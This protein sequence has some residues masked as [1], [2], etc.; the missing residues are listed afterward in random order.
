MTEHPY[1][2]MRWLKCDLHMHTPGDRRHWK[3]QKIVA[4]Q[5][6]AAAK[7]FARACYEA[8]LDVVGVTDHNLLGKAFLPH[9]QSAFE[10][11][12]NEFNH[13]ITMFPGVEFEA[14][15]GKGMHVVCLFDP[16]TDLEEIDH[17][18]TECGVPRPRVD[19]GTLAKSTKRLPRILDVVQKGN[20]E[21][22]WRGILIIPHV[23]D[24]SLFDNARISEWLQQEEFR[25]P[26]VLAAEIPKPVT[27][28]NY[29]FQKLFR[30]DDDCLPEWRRRRP[31]APLMSSD[32]KTLIETES[33]GRP[34]PN[35]IGYRYS[36][37]KMSEPSIEALRQAF[38]DH[39]S[40]IILPDD[41]SS[42]T[43]PENR[44][45]QTTIRSLSIKNVAFLTDQE[46]HF[47]PNMNCVIGGRG[48]GK[49]TLLE[50]LRIMLGKEET[51]DRDD[52]T[53]E[54]IER[55]RDTLKTVGAEL[56]VH[57]R[58]SD[59]AEDHIVWKNGTP[60]VD[61]RDLTDPDTF[62]RN[63]PVRFY[64]Q[65]QLNRL[66]EA[67]SDDGSVRQA[68][69]L[70]ALVDGFAESD[71]AL[72]AE[73]ERKLTIDIE[74]AFAHLRKVDTLTGDLKRLRQE[75]EELDRQCKARSEIQAEARRHQFL[76]SEQRYLDG[77]AGPTGKQFSDVVDLAEAVA[78]S[79]APFTVADSPHETWLQQF[80]LKVKA[81][82]DKLATDIRKAVE[83]FEENIES[84]KTRDP[85]WDS[86]RTELE[87][88]DEKF[89][90][91]CEAKG[92]SPDDI[93]H[94]KDISDARAAK[95]EEM[96]ATEAEIDQ[97]KERAGDPEALM[98]RLHNVWRDQY[99]K[100]EEAAKRANE[101]A[102][103]SDRQQRFIE[104]TAE[105]QQDV[106]SFQ[107]IW[108]GFA[109]QDGRTRLGR[110]W[111]SIGEKLYQ[112][113]IKQ[114]QAAS[115]WQLLNERLDD[116]SRS[117]GIDFGEVS[118]ELYEHIMDNSEAW[119]KLRCSRVQ[120]TVDMKLFRSDG[121]TAGSIS[122]GS[123]SDGQRNTASLALLLAQEG[124]PLVIDQ[125]ED[126][127]DSNFVFR[128]LIPMLRAVKTKRQLIMATHNAN[129]PVNGDS[130]L[131]YAFE[132][133]NGHGE[134]RAQGGL[135]QPLVTQ[136]VLDIMEG[137]EEAFRRRREKYHF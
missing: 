64:S 88:A 94:L 80:D 113:F 51:S 123:L 27:Q 49:S 61:N 81:A 31:I 66:T 84:L 106:R 129:L 3:G 24:D 114:N 46:I 15:V 133:R 118:E 11:I 136:A 98:D 57:W 35:S 10:D 72:L 71:L 69:R 54:R 22:R 29:A 19:R 23:F 125:P 99:G 115:P 82:K 122:E 38:L 87:Q 6:A 109:P 110:Y 62:F 131:V 56:V 12:K 74:D 73:Q 48:S 119:E 124:G 65:Q 45:R 14:D 20:S 30:A 9:L 33:D 70:L 47:S 75:H 28:L 89:S 100:R 137:T 104:V 97:L 42:D 16:D 117:A 1:K 102:T 59:G 85:R 36:W 67:K 44:T 7:E 126:E 63:L 103:F 95:Q 25:N 130:E 112:L 93:G 52:D 32:S 132:A 55:I 8:R 39:E 68:Q 58:S 34:A 86:I 76:K 26:N 101:L 96:E 116:A 4:G 105:Y 111:Q 107:E 120:D 18:L 83:L 77:L 91:A 5:E 41:V 90:E 50:Y 13:T 78:A 108:Q 121:T 37:I 134:L 53:A 40:R 79:H 43:H 128:E 92:L 2:G 21:G 135:D 17:V 60:V 127:L